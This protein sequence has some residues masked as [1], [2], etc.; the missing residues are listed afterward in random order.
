MI[1]VEKYFSRY[2]LLIDQISLFEYLY[3]VKYG[4]M[5]VFQVF[6]NSEI[7]HIFLMKAFS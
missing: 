6:V 1:F 3:F 2:S 4:A 5:C 7:N